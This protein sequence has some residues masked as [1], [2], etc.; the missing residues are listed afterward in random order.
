MTEPAESPLLRA[1]GLSVR[2]GRQV[3]LREVSLSLRRGEVVGLLGAN[4]AGKSTALAVLAGLQ[5]PRSGRLWLDGRVAI[6]RALRARSGLLPHRPPLHPELTVR[7]AVAHAAA[8]AGV[9]R[10]E[11]ADAVTD[12]L[13]RCDLATVHAR[14]AGNLS[15]GY[16]QRLG[17]ALALVHRPEVLL[18]DEPTVGLDP[19]QLARFR[20]LVRELAAGHAIL[21]S[22]HALAEVRR[23]CDRVLVLH[24]G[25]LTEAGET[26]TAGRRLLRLAPVPAASDLLALPGVASVEPLPEG[27][28][29]VT[30]KADGE[31]ACL[32]ALAAGGS[33]L[34][35][36]AP[37]GA[38]LERRF[39]AL[40]GSGAA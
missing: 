9:P 25:R 32:A 31:A 29:H 5:V 6:P 4:G 24:E 19:R 16:R 39:L 34:E 2:Y 13:A 11:R 7:Q 27:Y 15:Q 14:R 8:V 28:W 30:F 33:R 18:L 12:T 17:L 23:T 10:R 21:L 36:W 26:A 40:T 35:E 38:D 3:A 20:A 1:E 37:A 22:S